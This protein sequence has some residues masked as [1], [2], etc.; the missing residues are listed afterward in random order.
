MLPKVEQIAPPILETCAVSDL[1]NLIEHNKKFSTIYA[2]P[3]WKY[4]NQATRSATD[5]HYDTMAV[6]DIAL[7]PVSELTTDN[8]HLHLWTTNAFLFEAKEI[9]EMWGF[10]YKSCFVW[11]KPL[12]VSDIV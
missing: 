5:N 9:V 2:D 1:Q 3:P 7:L 4:D 6:E 8:A 10:E 11:V 12:K